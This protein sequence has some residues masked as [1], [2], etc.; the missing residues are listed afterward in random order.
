MIFGRE[1]L[2]VCWNSFCWNESCEDESRPDMVIYG[3]PGD[4][5]RWDGLS[6]VL[7]LLAP[8]LSSIDHLQGSESYFKLALNVY[9]CYGGS[10]QAMH[11][12]SVAPI[13]RS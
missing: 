1:F 4:L 11:N 12:S 8:F 10:V 2:S 7:F 6:I 5:P 13:N 9:R 3:N